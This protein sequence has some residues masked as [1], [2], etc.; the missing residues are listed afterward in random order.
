MKTKGFT[1]I[2]LLVVIGILAILAVAAILVLNPAQLFA[3]ARDS[4][5]INDMNNLKSAAA[6]YLS[7]VNSPA[8]ENDS[9]GGAV[10][11]DA[12]CAANFWGTIVGATENFT[13]APVLSTHYGTAISS[14]GTDDSWFPIKLGDISGGS[15]L[16]ALPTDP[17]N[18]DTADQSYTYRCDNSAK[19]FEINANMESTRYASGG[20][21]SVED[22]DG[23]D[24]STIF[25][26]GNDPGLNL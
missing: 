24:V 25:E 10:G 26:V 8:M 1:L 4:Q 16:S 22:S 20:N 3:E 14:A 23:G 6:L 2:E 15:P 9:N 13:G 11:A 5:R 18:P 12:T 21:S 19:T 17:L 7:T